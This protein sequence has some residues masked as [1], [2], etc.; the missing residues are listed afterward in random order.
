MFVDFELI[1]FKKKFTFLI[2]MLSFCTSTTCG[3]N[4]SKCVRLFDFD[5]KSIENKLN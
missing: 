3:P 1:E 2:S 5:Y 4:V